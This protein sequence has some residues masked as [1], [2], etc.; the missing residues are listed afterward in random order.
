[1]ATALADDALADAAERF[2]E[3]IAAQIPRQFHAAMTSSRTK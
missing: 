2:C 3:L 1:M